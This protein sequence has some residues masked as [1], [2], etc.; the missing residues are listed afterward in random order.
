V[1][2][3]IVEY[4]KFSSRHKK[5]VNMNQSINSFL[6]LSDKNRLSAFVKY[7]PNESTNVATSPT[8]FSLKK[9]SLF[10]RKDKI[11][12]R[13]TND[14]N[15]N[16]T[17]SNDKNSESEN[18]HCIVTFNGKALINSKLTKNY[19]TLTKANNKQLTTDSFLRSSSSFISL[20]SDNLVKFNEAIKKKP[21]Y[22]ALTDSNLKRFNYINRDIY[23]PNSKS[24]E[25][26]DKY[27]NDVNS[28][29][30]SLNESNTKRNKH[31]YI[32]ESKLV[33]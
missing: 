12:N 26:V 29:R 7:K 4:K 33:I 28:S 6:N 27:L 25:I 16:K 15:T 24:I 19:K 14:Y 1:R 17:I 8:N 30:K 22:A 23:L 21:Y 32:N 11:N 20:P 10:N 31:R 18:Y 9:Y 5:K 2:S 3:D 13:E